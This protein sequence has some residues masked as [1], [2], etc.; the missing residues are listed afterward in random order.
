[1]YRDIL[2]PI[3]HIVRCNGHVD[4][5]VL[6][7]G[8]VENTGYHRLDGLAV[9]M[10]NCYCDG[11]PVEIFHGLGPHVVIRAYARC[12]S[13]HVVGDARHV[14]AERWRTALLSIWMTTRTRT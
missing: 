13:F 2:L 12:S 6:L 4:E 1:L 3:R 5:V 11:Q 14:S 7:L 8:I 10:F 9:D